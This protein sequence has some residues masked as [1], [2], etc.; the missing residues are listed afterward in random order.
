MDS[1][2]TC[3]ERLDGERIDGSGNIEEEIDR[4]KN[5]QGKVQVH[6]NKANSTGPQEL[7]AEMLMNHS[8]SVL[9]HVSN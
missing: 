1:L 6:L 5:I 7:P 9:T 8:H 2:I 4:G 3:M